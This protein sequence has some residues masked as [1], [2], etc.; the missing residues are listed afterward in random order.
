[1][2]WIE[3]INCEDCQRMK[4]QGVPVWVCEKCGHDFPKMR[5]SCTCEGIENE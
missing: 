2:T 3:K 1:M 5:E 4:K